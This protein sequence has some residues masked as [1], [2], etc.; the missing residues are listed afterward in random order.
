MENMERT[1]VREHGEKTLI[2]PGQEHL[3]DYQEPGTD[4][5]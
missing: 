3:A 4:I 5:L 2:E 1:Q